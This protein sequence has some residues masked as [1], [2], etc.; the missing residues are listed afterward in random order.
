MV[1]GEFLWLVLAALYGYLAWKA[2]KS[3][4]YIEKELDPDRY[5]S[6]GIIFNRK[7]GT[8]LNLRDFLRIVYL[9]IGK[10]SLIGANLASAAC[11]ISF[12]LDLL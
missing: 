1:S 3:V 8:Q 2:K 11:T 12:I 6:G 5:S 4:D 9:D 7:D 10:A